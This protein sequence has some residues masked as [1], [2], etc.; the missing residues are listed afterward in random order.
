MPDI[1]SNELIE[2]N[3]MERFIEI[4]VRNQFSDMAGNSIVTKLNL[5]YP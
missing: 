3:G 2:D 5:E 4:G 1:D